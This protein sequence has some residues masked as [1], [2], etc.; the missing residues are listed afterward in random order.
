MRRIKIVGASDEDV[1]ANSR[2]DLDDIRGQDM[3]GAGRQY[4]PAM[5]ITALIRASNNSK[6]TVTGTDL[7]RRV[8]VGAG[9]RA[10]FEIAP[11]D[12]S[13]DKYLRSDNR[14]GESVGDINSTVEADQIAADEAL[15]LG[16]QFSVGNT[17]WVVVERRLEQF[18]PDKEDIQ[19]ITLKCVD[20][21]L[22]RKAQI[23]LI[24]RTEVL[25]PDREFISD[26]VERG[27]LDPAF[28]PLTRAA[29]GVVRN[30]KPA[31]V[32]E[33]GIRSK[34]FQRLNGLC[35]FNTVPTPSELDDFDDEEVQ[36]R[37]GTY[38][39]TIKRSSVFQV[40][41]R[42]AGVDENGN[43]FKFRRMDLYF[44]V[45]GSTPVNQ[46]NFIR[47]TH[48]G[49]EPVE[50][51]YQFVG[52][53]AS[54]LEVL[55]NDLTFIELS[56]SVSKQKETNIIQENL[57]VAGLGTFEVETAGRRIRKQDIFKNKE[58]LRKPEVLFEEETTSIPSAVKIDALLPDVQSG[59]FGT[60][61]AMVFVETLGNLDPP[62]RT[63]AFFHEIFG[64]ADAEAGPIGTRKSKQTREIVD[65]RALEINWTVVKAELPADHY[66]RVSNNQTH[67]WERLGADIVGSS[68]GFAV[69]DRLDLK[70]NTSANNPFRN[71]HPS[72]STMT[73]SGL[74]Y[75]VTSINEESVIKGRNGSYLYAIFGDA[76]QYS[77]GTQRTENRSINKSGKKITI[78]LNAQA[79]A[80]ASDHFSG[81]KQ[82]WELIG[83]ILVIDDGYTNSNWNKN[84]TFED[85]VSISYD[86]P[87]Y[88]AFT[89]VGFRYVVNDLRTVV[90]EIGLSGE[91]EFESHSQ[92]ADLSYY[93]GLVQKS[94]E[95]EPEHSIVYVNEILPNEIAP[96]YDGIVLAGLSLKASRNFT[97]LDQMRCWLSSGVHV[98]RLH[99]DNANAEGNPY[100]SDGSTLQ[101][102]IGP[103]NLFTDLVFY[104][105]TNQAAGAG[106]LLQ[107]AAGNPFLLN[108]DDFENTS[109]FIHKQKLFFNGVIAERTNL[110]QYITDT[111]PYFLCN[112]VITDGKFSLLPAVP[113]HPASGE[114]NTGPVQIDQMFTAGNILE[115]SYKLEYLRSEERRNFKAVL[116]YRK[117]SKNK[118]PEEKAIEVRFAS[119]EKEGP[120]EQFDLT[121]FCTSRDHAIKVAQYFLSLRKLVTHTISFSTTVHG[122]SLRAG[123]YIKVV[124]SSAPYNPAK[125]GTVDAN[126]VVTSASEIADGTYNVTYYS[127]NSEDVNEGE[128][129]IS[130][131][132]VSDSTFHNSVFTIQDLT[133]S[134]NVYIVEQ[135]TFS[136]EGT[137][138]IVAS[139]HPCDDDGVSK[140]AKLVTDLN[141]FT[142][143]DA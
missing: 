15:Q 50:L 35:A 14:G 46:Y 31:V 91:T 44:V 27:N 109:R 133:V 142:V 9:D 73:F 105:M 6:V 22:S 116:R 49:T 104:L 41:A 47:F 86:N 17:K 18:N 140:L 58:F 108:R 28:Y 81:Q 123:S 71:N 75:K 95:S 24:S 38:T 48:P 111:A 13:E 68:A 85:T 43:A 69:N 12:I 8:D 4:T 136:Q 131:G 135:L 16:E 66:A 36:I 51:E 103:S 82:A 106:T 32:T 124:T 141:S 113:H 26:G 96:Q 84:D 127:E 115:D 56:A 143:Q 79:V 80:L 107:M 2:D 93:R 70:R 130:N 98:T 42:K 112:F 55:G 87:F 114:I 3:R 138:D 77:L 62:G 64:S 21:D 61:T 65:G 129:P 20:T 99:P 120:V 54:E 128:M 94:N 92:C 125:N 10:E 101:Q 89:E 19:K 34:V 7:T 119:D 45:R 25:L 52:I 121:Q 100:A 122:L 29:T 11:F 59:T 117:E 40:F 53:E 30:N 78:Q 137:V 60:P 74:L 88:W 97:S 67:V 63:G 110:R 83:P 139:E 102:A 76:E 132:Q 126:G 37:S 90:E 1:G 57:D 134:Q 72:G 5:G 33:I 23:G 39:G 118:L